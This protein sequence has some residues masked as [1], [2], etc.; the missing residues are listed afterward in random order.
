MLN[1]ADWRGTPKESGR[2]RK[3]LRDVTGEFPTLKF[4]SE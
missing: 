2:E 3:D 1:P 4:D